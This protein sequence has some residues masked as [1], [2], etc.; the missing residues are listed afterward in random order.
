MGIPDQVGGEDQQGRQG[1]Q[2]GPG[3]AQGPGVGPEDGPEKDWTDQGHAILAEQAQPGGETRRHPAAAVTAQGGQGLVQGQG[4]GQGQ[5]GVRGGQDT[6]D[7]PTESRG[8][9]HQGQKLLLRGQAAG[10]VEADQHPQGQG[11]GEQIAQPARQGRGGG[12]AGANCQE[13]NPRGVIEIAPVQAA[14][15]IDVISL[16]LGHRQQ[17]GRPQPPEADEGEGQPQPADGGIRGPG[18]RSARG[19]KVG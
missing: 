15:P 3:G 1:P 4:P 2:V 9:H 12:Q 10:A 13:G 14:R 8:S 18:R 19:R 11:R 5:G 17:P 7:Q 6:G 16:I